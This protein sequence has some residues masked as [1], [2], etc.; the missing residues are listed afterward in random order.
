MKSLSTLAVQSYR[1]DG[2]ASLAELVSREPDGLYKL[3]VEGETLQCVRDNG[4]V[5]PYQLAFEPSLHHFRYGKKSRSKRVATSALLEVRVGPLTQTL[6]TH[7]E[8]EQEA[9]S[10]ALVYRAA[11]SGNI[12]VPHTVSLLCCSPA[13]RDQWAHALNVLMLC[14]QNAD[15]EAYSLVHPF[16]DHL[17][18]ASLALYNM[19]TRTC[20]KCYYF[21]SLLGH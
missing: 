10:F 21:S 14:M 8:T 7:C 2:S 18:K 1:V 11:E 13:R 15:A 4:T 19:S 20:F 5:R 17:K 12:A 3:L 16:Q 6:L 9:R